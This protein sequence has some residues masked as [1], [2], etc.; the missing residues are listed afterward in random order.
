M[1]LFTMIGSGAV[2][3]LLSTSVFAQEAAGTAS[4]STS[5]GAQVGVGLPA[6]Q[7]TTA[8]GDSDH[9]QMVHRF[10]VGYMGRQTM[11][12]G[13]ARTPVAAPVIGGR[14]WLDQM[15]GIDAGL[16]LNFSGGSTSVDGPGVSQDN[17]KAGLTVFLIHVGV[18]L[19]LADMNHFSF[20]VVPEANVGFAS[21]GDQD[22]D[23]A[24]EVTDS[25]FHLSVGARAGAE[26]HF[27][28]MG[29]PQL[30]LQG[31]VGLYLQT[32]T[33]TTETTT[34]GAT[35][36]QKDTSTTV[37]TTLGPDPWDLFTGS[38]SALYYF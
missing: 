28:F 20:Q 21:T 17:D 3:A 33:G 11:T 14:Y 15:I 36:E 31:D 26:I 27:G 29:I 22:P 9:A 25:G 5:G 13:N 12:L 18:P 37:G 38:I 24:D 32:E 19:S 8:Y 23:P 6:A 35:T 1:K 2:A 4:A 7:T 16:G 34:G 30:S 10:A